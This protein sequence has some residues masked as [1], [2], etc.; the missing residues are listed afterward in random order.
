MS[1]RVPGGGPRPEW[2]AEPGSGPANGGDRGAPSPQPAQ[3]SPARDYRGPQR[4]EQPNPTR[5]DNPRYQSPG[6]SAA[7][8]PP[9]AGPNTKPPGRG[10]GFG[11]PP[12]QPSPAKWP[13]RPPA[14][15]QQPAP[16]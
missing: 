11:V 15:G 12:A 2:P 10:P 3:P 6:A 16:G 9:G 7:P 13:Q 5:P 4:F 14:P 8:R 1:G